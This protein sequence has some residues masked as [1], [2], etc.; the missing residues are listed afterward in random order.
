ME[1]VPKSWFVRRYFG[2]GWYPAT[3][4]GWAVSVLYVIFVILAAKMLEKVVSTL[5]IVVLSVVFLLLCKYK[6]RQPSSWVD[7][8][9]T[10]WRAGRLG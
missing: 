8:K 5:V 4:E 9:E 10:N 3:W 6:G 1:K 7:R 2:R